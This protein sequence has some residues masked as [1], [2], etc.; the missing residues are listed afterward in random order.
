MPFGLGES[1]ESSREYKRKDEDYANSVWACC[2][3]AFDRESVQKP[4]WNHKERQDCCSDDHRYTRRY[5]IA[6]VVM[7]AI[8][9]CFQSAFL[10]VCLR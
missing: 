4:N 2:N 3:F 7:Y 9:V 10:L 1:R 6:I 5:A 8:F